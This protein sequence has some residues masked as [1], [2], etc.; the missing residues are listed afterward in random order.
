MLFSSQVMFNSFATPWTVTH[1]DPL[2]MEFPRQEYSRG[3]PFPS[4]GGLPIP[5]IKPVSP[6]VA[7]GFFT[8]EP[9]GKPSEYYQF[10]YLR[11][12]NLNYS[13]KKKKSQCIIFMRVGKCITYL[14]LYLS[15]F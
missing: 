7:G 15:L 14:L 2:S 1:Q 4:P 8:T 11:V 9:P 13:I 3:L 6:A 10:T 5:R 12:V